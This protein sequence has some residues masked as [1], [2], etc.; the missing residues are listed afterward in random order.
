MAPITRRSLS[1]AVAHRVRS[2][3]VVPIYLG[4]VVSDDV[5]KGA[6]V[7]LRLKLI[8]ALAP[9]TAPCRRAQEVA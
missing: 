8:S 2:Y 3:K 1:V 9:L 6:S 7:E 5:A 4:P